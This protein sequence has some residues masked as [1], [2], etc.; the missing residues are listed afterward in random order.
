MTK[1]VIFEP[2]R[3]GCPSI[4][5]TMK[6]IIMSL[7]GVKKVTVHYDERSLE[8]TFDES[9]VLQEEIARAIGKETGIAIEVR[10]ESR[11]QKNG[12]SAANTCPM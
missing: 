11:N 2:S 8:V 5:G 7:Q 12:A 4:P 10:S 6:G 3:I 1:T 9:E